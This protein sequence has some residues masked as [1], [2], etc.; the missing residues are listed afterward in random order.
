MLRFLSRTRQHIKKPLNIY[1]SSKHPSSDY[2]GKT[3]C[4]IIANEI[5]NVSKDVFV[6]TGGAIMPVVDHVYKHD[7]NH[8]ILTHEQY[9][10][11]AA[12][13]YN[14]ASGKL[15]PCFV[16]SGPG[17]TNMVT[18]MQ[19]ATTDSSSLLIFSGQVPVSKMGSQ[20][21]QEAPST[22]ISKSV[23]KYNYCIKDPRKIYHAIQNSVFACTNNRKGAVHIDLPKD[24]VTS[25]V[26]EHSTVTNIDDRDYMEY[27]DIDSHS[28]NRIIS[29]IMYAKRPVLYVGQ[30][31]ND[32]PKLL[33]LFAEKFDIPV[34]T[35]IHAN[36][37]FDENNVLSLK[38]LGMHGS[39]VANY[40]VQNADLII[41][42]GCRFDDRTTGEISKYAPKA[43]EASKN[44]TGGIIFCN[45][46]L[47]TI[48]MVR[49]LVYFDILVYNTCKH[50]L[51]HVID[52]RSIKKNY[53]WVSHLSK[54]KTQ[55]KFVYNTPPNG[56]INTQMVIEEIN[57]QVSGDFIITTGV[58][59]HQMMTSQF[60]T[61]TKPRSFISSGSL[62]VMGTGLPYAI[63][64]QIAC[65][66]KKV[67]LI[68]G[69][70][71]FNMSFNEL[72]SVAKYNLPIKIFIMNDS[73]LSMVQTWENLF[74]D[75][76]TVATDL[77][78]PDYAQL[79]SAF[80]IQSYVCNTKNDL[81]DK[82]KRTLNHPGPVLCEFV[83]ESDKCFPLVRPGYALDDVIHPQYNDK[84]IDTSKP[85]PS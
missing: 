46:D 21:F 30:G 7:F 71:S 73:C 78:N 24:V 68:D 58:G 34:T 22:E 53:E 33:K 63:G 48:K 1:F 31:C 70:G 14:R 66:D 11:H 16:T 43:Y 62:G 6:Y 37:V 27:T 57:R 51:E 10:G 32:C 15:S 72:V 56:K 81:Q 29:L 18:P 65:P 69:D 79:A 2:I 5:K 85:P 61:W 41:A 42:L 8:Y 76:R 20:A 40:A 60:I 77:E 52:N 39:Y 59:N 75:G 38:F 13:G 3:G 28:L 35:T 26:K 55:Y 4:E 47:P 50:F 9:T 83:V 45:N 12:I 25:V 23:T 54:M 67:I 49:K 64:A 36:G 44:G 80:K 17:L 19:D 84:Q 74:F 82:V